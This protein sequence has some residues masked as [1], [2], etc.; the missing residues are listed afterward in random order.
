MRVSDAERERVAS[1]LREQA[2][3][4]RLDHEELDERLGRCYRAVTVGHLEELI[5]DLPQRRV[6]AG[7]PRR[8]PAPPR[9]LIGLG[10]AGLAALT[11]PSVIAVAFAL[12]IAAGVAAVAVLF[13]LGFVFGPFI[14]FGLL[15]ALAAR[16]RRSRHWHPRW[17]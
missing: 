5:A 12:V 8:Q 6:P 1:F 17:R 7:P 15:I 9:A 16:R 14:L 10:V 2:L 13:A 3:E 11:V 4:G